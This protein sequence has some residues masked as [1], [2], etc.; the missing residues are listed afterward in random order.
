MN[1]WPENRL[2]DTLAEQLGLI[3]TGLE[4]IEVEHHLSIRTVPPDASTSLPG[5]GRV[6]W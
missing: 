6:T 5:I 2:R 1:P 4:L 3:E